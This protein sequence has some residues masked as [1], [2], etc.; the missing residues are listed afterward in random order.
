MADVLRADLSEIYRRLYERLKIKQ[1]T[2]MLAE[3]GVLNQVR[4][5]IDINQDIFDVQ[6]FTTTATV[7]GVGDKTITVVPEGKRWD[8]LQVIAYRSSGTWS[9]EGAVI[10]RAK[11]GTQMW[12]VYAPL[13]TVLRFPGNTYASGTANDYHVLAPI[14]L[15][16]GDEILIPIDAHSV[17]GT[18]ACVV[19]AREYDYYG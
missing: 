3:S 14:P 5:I 9:M 8:L 10:Y 18:L 1:S 2:S 4:P 17:N 11:T 6:H 19:L 15:L 16:P 13:C 7:T 12:F